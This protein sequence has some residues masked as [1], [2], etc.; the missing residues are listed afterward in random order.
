MNTYENIIQ[1]PTAFSKNHIDPE[2]R[3]QP[4]INIRYIPVLLMVD[5]PPT[6]L[7]ELEAEGLHWSKC[8]PV[9]SVEALEKI[10]SP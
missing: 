2:S 8:V 1:H 4:L 10:W 3:T 7:L 5:S 6:F 9:T